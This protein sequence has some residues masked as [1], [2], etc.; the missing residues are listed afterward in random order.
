MYDFIQSLPFNPDILCLSE[1]RIK[2]QSL[3]NIDFPRYNFLNVNSERSA[4]GVAI[5]ISTNSKQIN[6]ETY[7]LYRTESLQ[8][9]VYPI[10]LKEL[11]SWRNLSA[12]K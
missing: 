9:N 5:Y 10:H 12:P 1:S 3:L 4:G 6:E 2:K 8:L 7:T 11:Y